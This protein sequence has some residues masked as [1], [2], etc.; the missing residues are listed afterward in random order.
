[1]RGR[2][3]NPMTAPGRLDT[4]GDRQV[5]LAGPRRAQEHHVVGLGEEVQLGEM[6]DLGAFDR[7]LEAEVEVVEGLD[8]WEACAFDP[9]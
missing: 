6:R 9:R 5:R 3:G 8:L 2:E 4:Q 7:A 1:M